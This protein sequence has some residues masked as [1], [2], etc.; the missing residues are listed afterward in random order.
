MTEEDIAYILCIFQKNLDYFTSLQSRQYP[1]DF[2]S[3]F[4]SGSSSS[5]FPSEGFVESISPW[6]EE[7]LNPSQLFEDF[8][9]S[10]NSQSTISSPKISANIQS[11]GQLSLPLPPIVQIPTTLNPLIV[12]T[13]LVMAQ[14]PTRMDL[15]VVARY[16]PLVLPQPLHPLP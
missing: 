13:T 10:V 11:S 5:F 7:V 12:H 1:I 16:A 4:T 9:D 15:I 3:H 2:P 8:K 6:F 14:P